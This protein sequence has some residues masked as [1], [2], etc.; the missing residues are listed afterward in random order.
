MKEQH[1]EL[2]ELDGQEMEGSKSG[3][4]SVV[5]FGVVFATIVVASAGGQES[6]SGAGARKLSAY[7]VLCSFRSA[8]Y[9]CSRVR[10]GHPIHYLDHR[11]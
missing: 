9:S 5:Q 2:A 10:V 4:A 11:A 3:A 1:E 8:A 6:Q 7:L